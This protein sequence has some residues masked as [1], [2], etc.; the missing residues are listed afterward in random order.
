MIEAPELLGTKV[1]LRPLAERDVPLLARWY[2]DPEVVHWVH[3]SEDPPE[4]RTLEAHRERYRG[5]RDDP[6]RI[7]WCIETHGGKPI[8]DCALVD[9]HAH[10]RAELAITIGEKDYWARGYGTDAVCAILDFAFD[11]LRLRR[12]YLITDADNDRAIRC[13]EKCGFARE[14]LLRGHRLRDGRP[15]DMWTMGVMREEYPPG[16]T[17]G[18]GSGPRT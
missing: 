11:A 7:P 3:L 16:P 4:L 6:R 12:V 13:Y 2:T 14:G 1:R 5:I 10:G 15:L 8:G 18:E 9:L 17:G